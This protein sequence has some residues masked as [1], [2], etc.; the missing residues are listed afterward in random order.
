MTLVFIIALVLVKNGQVQVQ[1]LGHFGGID[2]QLKLALPCV[3]TNLG[4]N[5]SVVVISTIQFNS[6]KGVWSINEM[7][8]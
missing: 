5:E 2:T 6:I 8:S 7:K 3:H 1:I 4:L